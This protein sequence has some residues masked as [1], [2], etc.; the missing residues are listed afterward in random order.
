[1]IH[2]KLK[3]K[4]EAYQDIQNGIEWYNS[5][6]NRLGKRFHDAIKQEFKTLR[7]N[8]FF[9]S[10]IRLYSLLAVKE[11]PLHGTLHRR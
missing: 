4:P 2:Y 11:I 10:T 8:P 6:Q 1:M 5:R 3:I 9:Q 7:K